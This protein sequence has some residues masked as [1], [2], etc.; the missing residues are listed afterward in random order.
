M[1][2]SQIS[3][4][5]KQAMKDKDTLKL[6]VLRMVLSSL[7]NEAINLNK[8]D[9]GLSDEEALKVLK[10][11]VKKRKDS[12]EQYVSGGREDLADHEKKE[13]EILEKYLPEEMGESE[14]KQIVESVI[15]EMGGSVAPSQFGAVMKAVMTKTAGSADGAMVTRIV[16]ESLAR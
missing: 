16:K 10:K 1:L 3:A 12:I 6:S 2:T 8:K 15:A 4:D 9:A 5:I 7:N 13:L 14:I 11:E